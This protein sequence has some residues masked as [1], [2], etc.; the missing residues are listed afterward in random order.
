MSKPKPKPK[1]K[2]RKNTPKKKKLKKSPKRTGFLSFILNKY[3]IITFTLLTLLF[4][5]YLVFLNIKIT[6]KMSGRIWSLPSHVFARPLELYQGKSLSIKQFNTELKQIGYT[7]VF[8]RPTKEGQYR[9]LNNSHFE[10][11]SRDFTYWDGLQ[12]SQGI[13]LSIYNDKISILHK[14]Y[15]DETLALFRMEP[16]KNCRYISIYKTGSTVNKTR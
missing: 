3:T 9:V 7:Q 11:I 4:T 14:L 2:A 6:D 8:N 10:L 1:P 5:S 15:S 13:R 12:K 16:V